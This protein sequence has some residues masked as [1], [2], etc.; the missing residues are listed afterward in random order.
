MNAVH[1]MLSTKPCAAAISKRPELLVDDAVIIA[2]LPTKTRAKVPRNSEYECR[3]I[4][5]FMGS[6][7]GVKGAVA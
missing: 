7:A 4:S 1:I 6:S 3:T 5:E 2:P